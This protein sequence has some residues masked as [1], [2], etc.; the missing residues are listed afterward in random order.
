MKLSA[1]FR[2]LAAGTLA[3]GLGFTA[4]QSLAQTAPP[5]GLPNTLA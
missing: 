2:R 4:M 3:C 1:R 5:P